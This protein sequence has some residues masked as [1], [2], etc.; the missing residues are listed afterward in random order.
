MKIQRYQNTNLSVGR[1]RIG[2]KGQSV[3]SNINDSIL[4]SHC[5]KS[6]AQIRWEKKLKKVQFF[7][8]YL[9]SVLLIQ[10]NN[11]K[12]KAPFLFS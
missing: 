8:S 11:F 2:N 5:A 3:T 6:R 9:S 1:Q 7:P 10:H 12:I 4:T